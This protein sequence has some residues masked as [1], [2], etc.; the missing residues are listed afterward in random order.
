MMKML[1]HIETK[2][3]LKYHPPGD[4]RAGY[5]R[6]MVTSREKT[7]ELQCERRLCVE[8]VVRHE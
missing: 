1:D 3:A 2:V 5:R 6:T 7:P 4:C 8:V